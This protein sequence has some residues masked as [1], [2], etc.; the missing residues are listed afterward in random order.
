VWATGLASH[1]L[2]RVLAKDAVTSPLRAPFTHYEKP[3]GDAELMESARHGSGHQHALGEL[4][5]CP[6]CLD[7]W[8]ASGFAA[9]TV[10]A[11]RPTRLAMLVFAGTA[12]SDAL[13]LTYASL[14]KLSS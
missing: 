11:P 14:Q 5:T 1:K 4:L 7:Q 12:V 6:F 9:G 2:S 10:L 3:A 13:Q 8:A